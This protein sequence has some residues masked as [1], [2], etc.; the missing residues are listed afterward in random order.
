MK[1]IMKDDSIFVKAIK[2]REN[3]SECIM[4]LQWCVSETFTASDGEKIPLLSEMDL[5][6]LER[7]AEWLQSVVV[8]ERR[9]RA[10]AEKVQ[11]IRAKLAPEANTSEGEKEMVRQWLQARGHPTE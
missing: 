8:K 3:L 4:H 5:D 6:S 1:R 11:S 10:D 9:R 7:D 2:H